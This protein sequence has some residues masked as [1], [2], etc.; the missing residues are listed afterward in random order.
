MTRP[1]M[2]PATVTT[3][4]VTW[5]ESS[6]EARTTTCRATSSGW[7][8][9]RS[10]IV[11]ETRRTASGSTWPRVIGDSVQPGATAFTRAAR[12]DPDDL[13]LQAQEQPAEHRRLG[14][15][16][17]RVPC[18]ADEARRRADEHERAVPVSLHLAQEAA[19]GQERRGQVLAQRLLPALERQL[20]DGHVLRRPDAGDRGADVDPA[21][22]RA[23]LCEEPVDLVLVGQVGLEH[24]RAA[25][26]RGDLARPLLAAVVVD[27]DARALGRERAGAGGADAARCAGDEH[28]LA[29]EPGL[30][31]R[32]G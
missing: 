14:G 5:P 11:R 1:S 25:E 9:L 19:G 3:W 23:R 15:R 32:L 17:V 20:P 16:I 29:C 24:R 12:R 7:A 8:T 2:P 21:E 10:A 27:G 6:S 30:H 13:V 31:V 26:L 18:L 28:A 22:R 4:P